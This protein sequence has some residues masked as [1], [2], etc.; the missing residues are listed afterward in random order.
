MRGIDDPTAGAVLIQHT[1]DAGRHPNQQIT[2]HVV[3]EVTA[4]RTAPEARHRAVRIDGAH[5]EV[6]HCLVAVWRT[7]PLVTSTESTIAREKAYI[8]RFLAMESIMLK[9][10]AYPN[11]DIRLRQ[12]M[13]TIQ[14]L[15]L[16][17]DLRH[18]L[19]P[20]L[21][22][23]FVELD[24]QMGYGQ[25]G[26]HVRADGT[27]GPACRAKSRFGPIEED[28]DSNQR[29]RANTCRRVLEM[30][31]SGPT[32]MGSGRTRTAQRRDAPARTDELQTARPC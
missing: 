8:V 4:D 15:D 11:L 29:L 26:I 18:D 31:G 9:K 5:K 20:K 12:S 17:A 30:P 21:E 10:P 2:R 22:N 14:L 16:L 23:A 25:R 24:C 1:P 6:G 32:A 7:R 3:N 27:Y 19:R 28:H 13:E